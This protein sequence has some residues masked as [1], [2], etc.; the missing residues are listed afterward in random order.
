VVE[1]ACGIGHFIGLVP[2]EMLRRSSITGVEI[3]PLRAHI[4][5]LTRRDAVIPSATEEAQF[6]FLLVG[7]R[8]VA[9][10]LAHGLKADFFAMR[11]VCAENLPA[12]IPRSRVSAPHPAISSFQICF[13]HDDPHPVCDHLLPLPRAKDARRGGIILWDVFPGQFGPSRTGNLTTPG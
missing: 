9:P 13:S 6:V 1:S 3:D 5:G 10:I 8:F 2:E 12:S 11:K 7:R 4:A